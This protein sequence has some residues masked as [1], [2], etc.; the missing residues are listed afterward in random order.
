MNTSI[1]RL[2]LM[3]VA[4]I[5]ARH[6]PIVCYLAQTEDGTNIL[7][8]SGLAPNTQPPPGSPSSV[9]GP[10]V[11]EQLA[12]IGLKPDDIKLFVATHF[13]PD[14]AGNNDL[15]PNAEFV[16][17]RTMYE[18]A[19]THPRAAISRAHWDQPNLR[20]RF[21]DGD[22]T[23]VPG[24]ELI[25]TSGHVPGHQ[26]V[27]VRLPETG[28]VLLAIDAV[29]LQA[30]FTPDGGPGPMDDDPAMARL[31]KLKLLGIAEREKPAL[32]VFGH[33]G[34]QWDT[35]RKLPEYYG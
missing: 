17:Q 12:M 2:Y 11:I 29:T 7:I 20:Y 34:Q 6:L 24:L 9:M 28:V 14:H 31:S 21:V 25:E 35:L 32:V 13:D 27:L 18:R 1:R 10:N 3:Q 16:V 23:L 8:D 15:F 30:L 33:D 19:Q 4:S 22:T 5:P 26:S